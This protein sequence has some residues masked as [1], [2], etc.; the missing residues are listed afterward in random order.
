MSKQKTYV[1]WKGRQPG[2]YSSWDAC[3]AQVE[4]YTG[5]VYKSFPTRA[6]A[7]TA[8]RKP[9]AE[10]IG[11]TVARIL[12]PADFRSLGITHPDASCALKPAVA[13]L[14]RRSPHARRP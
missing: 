2:I 8:Y 1:V 7:E 12:T 5:A 14:F 3:K 11:Q 6:E 13:P 4:G 9:P 10:F